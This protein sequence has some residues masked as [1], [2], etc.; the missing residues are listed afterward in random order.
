VR[1]S[2]GAQ[3]IDDMLEDL[4]GTKVDWGQTIQEASAVFSVT[5]SN[6]RKFEDCDIRISIGP[7][8]AF[9]EESNG[10]SEER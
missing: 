9:Y 3:L 10:R 2:I 5:L 8:G 7:P 6:L 4:L 1:K